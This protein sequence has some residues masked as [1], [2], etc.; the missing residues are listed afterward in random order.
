MNTLA[1]PCIASRLIQV[2]TVEELKQ[3]YS[4]YNLDTGNSLIIGSGSNVVLPEILEITVLQF[5]ASAIKLHPQDDVSVNIEVDAGVL[6]DDLV[7][8]MV[9]KGLRGIE[10]L[11]LI[12]G[13]VGAAPVQN[14]GAYGVEVSD[15]LLSVEVFNVQTRE[16]ETIRHSE[17]DFSYRDSAFKQNPGQFLILKVFLNLSKIRPFTLGYGELKPLLGRKNLN[18]A[19]IRARVI[20]VRQAKLPDPKV[21]P[22]VGSFFKNPLV[23][24]KQAEELKAQYPDLVSYQLPLNV[25]SVKLAA[26]WLIDH[27]GWKGHRES[28]VGVHDQQALVL[29]NHAG[30]TQ[31]ELLSLVGKIKH[32][33][34]EKFQIRL[35][36]E[37]VIII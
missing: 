12:P 14:I 20:E 27:A 31:Q 23:S 13:T 21:L 25:Q 3:V 19:A 1:L 22:N 15:L 16:V 37:P 11:S 17:C 5:T 10:N 33:V 4:S 28:R 35:E 34:W 36:P 29:I 6:W 30:G 26:G 8:A 7:K 32:S 24:F 2:D 18:V 9:D